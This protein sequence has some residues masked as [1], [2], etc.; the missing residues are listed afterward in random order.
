MSILNESVPVLAGEIVDSTFMDVAALRAF[1]DA[2]IE[3]ARSSGV[4]FSLQKATMMKVSTPSFSVTLCEH[5]I[6][7]FSE[8]GDVLQDAEPTQITVLICVERGRQRVG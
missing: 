5:F 2:Q 3:D 7:T 6:E 1:L 8:F 4:L